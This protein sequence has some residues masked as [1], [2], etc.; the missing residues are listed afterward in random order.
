M[1]SAR[2]ASWFRVDAV[3]FLAE[4]WPRAIALDQASEPFVR[5]RL[6]RQGLLLL[7]TVHWPSQAFYTRSELSRLEDLRGSRPVP[8]DMWIDWNY[9]F[10]IPGMEER[11][12]QWLPGYLERK[13][14]REA[15]GRR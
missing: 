5:A 10:E 3:P 2:T 6:E 13:R 1:P 9:F 12:Q 4:T 7:Y 11:Y 14:Q 15:E 8:A